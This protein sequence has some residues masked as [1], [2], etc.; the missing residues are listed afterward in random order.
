VEQTDLVERRGQ[1]GVSSSRNFLTKK[2]LEHQRDG[3]RSWKGGTQRSVRFVEKGI[4]VGE[5]F[6]WMHKLDQENFLE[7][8]VGGQR[9]EWGVGTGGSECLEIQSE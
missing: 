9:R 1:L 4:E 2:I 5:E 3:R 8:G 6:V 7:S